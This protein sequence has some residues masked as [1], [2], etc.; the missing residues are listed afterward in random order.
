MTE[1]KANETSLPTSIKPMLARLVRE[2]FDSPD[3]IYELKWDGFRTVAFVE[4]GKVR[5]Q[6]R[7]AK[8]MT[9]QFPEMEGLV[10]QVEAD[11]LAIDGELVCLDEDGRPSI[12]LMQ[13]RFQRGQGKPGTL[14]P[15]SF[16]AFDLLHLR[17]E[18]VMGQPL[19]ERKR[20]LAEV[21]NP[22]DSIIISQS[23]ET[24]GKAFFQAT[25]D[26]GLEGVVAKQ[27]AS[28]YLPGKRTW[29]WLKVKRVREGEFVI[30]GYVFGG[31]RKDY[32][33]SLLLGL[34]DEDGKLVYVGSAGSGYS[35]D[36][37]RGI[38]ETLEPS[39]VEERP[40]VNTPEV[41]EK[42]IHWCKPELVCQ[43]E[44]GEFTVDGRLRY[45]VYVRMRPDKSP[46]ECVLSDVPGWP[47]SLGGGEG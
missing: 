25:C 35:E 24:D 16:I 21:L 15:V 9:S 46:D 2:P 5:L 20:L 14:P 28:L 11:G 18:S 39:I 34:H 40:F 4:D 27:K 33:S 12:K 42:Y 47:R 43:V 38:Y 8:T 7:N 1:L 37:V 44:Y 22:S 10:K 26:L 13:Q 30:G 17:G 36:E 19:Q 29:S 41:Q 23:V 31:Q 32:F 45:P 3:W 6:S